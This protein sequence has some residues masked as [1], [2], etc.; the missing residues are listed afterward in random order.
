MNARFVQKTEL[1]RWE[2]FRFRPTVA[3]PLKKAC[4]RAALSHAA[5]SGKT[6]WRAAWRR[7][8][9]RAALC[10]TTVA[11]LSA[12][13]MQPLS[14]GRADAGEARPLS[15]A[16]TVPASSRSVLPNGKFDE[17]DQSPAGW[18]LSGGQGQWVDRSM[19]EITGAGKG[20]AHWSARGRFE[21]GGFYRFSMI[22]RAVRG[23]GCVTSGPSFA[24]HDWRLTPQWR[25]YSFVFRAADDAA[26]TDVRLGHWEAD[27]TLQFDQVEIV[28]VVPVHRVAPSLGL[29]G[30]K[31]TLGEGELIRQGRY[32]FSAR[33]DGPVGICHRPLVRATAPL[34]TN[35]WCFVDGK[36]VV[37]RFALPGALLSE[38][39]IEASVCY[40]A[41]G[42]LLI[43]YGAD[44][45]QWREAARADA[46][47][48]VRA[49]LPAD[50]PPT[51]AV[52]LR[53][54][55]EDRRSNL[56]V[57]RLGVDARMIAA[58]STQRPAVEPPAAFPSAPPPPLATAS[59]PSTP[60]STPASTSASLSASTPAS[61]A[62]KPIGMPDGLGEIVIGRTLFAV[63]E[64]KAAGVEIERIEYD[65]EASLLKLDAM[66]LPSS[67]PLAV[68]AEVRTTRGPQPADT[69]L[70]EIGATGKASL[71]VS[72]GRLQPGTNHAAVAINSQGRTLLRLGVPVAVHHYH[73]SDYGRLL[74]IGPE[75]Q[76]A[77]LW[78]CEAGWKV[79]PHRA[80]P[81]QTAAAI[82][83]EAARGDT[84]A[85]QLVLRPTTA[86][87]G[88]RAEVGPLVGP[89]GARIEPS[90]VDLLRVAY[91]FVEHPTDGSG[92]VDWW[93]DA[94]PPLDQPLD[95]PAAMNQ[96]LWVRVTVPENAAAGEYRGTVL[97]R[98]DGFSAAVPLRLRVW[99]FALPR[100]NHLATAFGLD[101]GNI[102]R[103]HRLKTEED[104]R[105]VL[106]AY[107]RSF[108]RAR[109]SPYNPAPLDPIRVRLLPE[110][111]PPRAEVD[112]T[113]FDAA[114]RR[115]IEEYRFTHFMLPLEGMGGGTFHQR[116]EP[117][118]GRFGADT[119]E[120]QRTF[121]DY[122]GKIQRHL[123]E[124]SWV[125]M[126]YTY[127][128]D[129]PDPK[130]YAFV[131]EGMER[132][133][134]YAP[135]LT[136][137]LTE[138]PNEA[139]AG[140]IDIWCP[141]TE[142]YRHEE[143]QRRIAAG[144][145][146]W[147][148]VCCGP[149]APYCTLFIDHPATELRVWLW[150]SWQRNIS[151]VLI[152]SSNYWTSATAFPDSLQNPYADPMSYVSGYGV[153]KGT[154]QFWGNGDGRF[155]YPPPEAAAGRAEGPPI[156]AGPVESIRWEMLR[157]G[158]EDWEML[159]LLRL[160]IDHRGSNDP[161]LRKLLEVPEEI[162]RSLTEFTAD[163]TPIHDHRRRV[164]EA[165]ERLGRD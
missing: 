39:R 57:D 91:H 142:N 26:E 157:E 139:L 103:Y 98:A 111:D 129:E 145:K 152:W 43:E 125:S 95:L 163:P 37:Y 49:E 46:V 16:A 27:G 121:A 113:R 162:T 48:M 78:W 21:P 164:A 119:P 137:M 96:P 155:L 74:P 90:A 118:I 52:W 58:R 24:N 17:G 2:S 73:R 11:L 161:Q 30:G 53:L 3:A 153:P 150:Q 18:R 65:P 128:F 38:V 105:R 76:S 148:Y 7:S 66:G 110:A 131:R 158:I 154:K 12:A 45:E 159:Y 72:L 29:G 107:F 117:K 59:S 10:T 165:I 6:Q 126:A 61:S 70:T 88:L 41:G 34:N 156:T 54:R 84:E 149:K 50:T 136:N 23:D 120:Y 135:K 35:R 106:D 116:W 44:G 134:R 4:S 146:L 1:A 40:R 108:A 130:D 60:A 102:W 100:Q 109:I 5:F 25:E 67:A 82:E 13:L 138:E 86:L 143:A 133:K 83:L 64:E 51:G 99:D 8:A 68:F 19:L 87:R 122:L 104:K 55:G 69:A 132:I 47:G 101:V 22:A 20:S 151:G 85:A 141:V 36:E 144:E 9:W 71:H 97:L 77:A 115:A 127:W 123:E 147:W 94:L 160:R 56:Q 89:S 15:A 140:A 31:F 114:W 112:F 80:L 62:A 63:L 14:S 75:A 33:F 79:W 124:Q 42:R 93:P 92:I 28:P 81:A 32:Q